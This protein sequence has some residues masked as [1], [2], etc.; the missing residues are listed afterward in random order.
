MNEMGDDL[1]NCILV[2]DVLDKFKEI[3]DSSVDL[4]LTSPPYYGLR[5]YD[6]VKTQ[7]GLEPSLEEYLTRMMQV[8][9]ECKRVL[10]DSGSYW[11][12]IG[13]TYATNGK[14]VKHKDVKYRLDSTA[15]RKSL[16][17]VPER[18]YVRMLDD[19]WLSRNKVLWTKWHAMPASVKDRLTNVHEPLYFFTKGE[20]YY[21]NLELV[22]E[23]TV[24]K[25]KP[26]NVRVRDVKRGLGQARL[27]HATDAEI[28]RYD[29]HGHKIDTKAK[30]PTLDPTGNSARLSV[31]FNNN[32]GYNNYDKKI[33]MNEHLSQAEKESAKRELAKIKGLM[34]EGK[35]TSFRMYLRNE[36]K[37]VHGSNVSIS[38]RAREVRDKGYSFMIIYSTGKNPGDLLVLPFQPLPR[39]YKHHAVFPLRLPEFVL[40]ASAPLF[41]CCKCGKPQMPEALIN[42]EK[43]E[44]PDKD[45]NT[46]LY[47][48]CDCNAEWKA[49]RVLDMFAGAGTTLCVAK[50]FGLR[51][52]GI[53]INANYVELMKER[54]RDTTKPFKSPLKQV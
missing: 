4:I 8:N 15:P 9:K 36:G 45:V 26:Y 33:D 40:G 31:N 20:D 50:A 47:P 42:L 41:V 35:V 54:L 27:T 5:V 25:T 32:R 1:S 23:P 10:K 46:A 21:F 30:F 2:G 34:L 11:L 37:G 53:E 29:K 39:K 49:G 13:D 3:P 17:G 44:G 51:Y 6:D 43:W 19:K 22:K 12:N 28:Q 18:L 14:V 16:M 52:V 7:W 48:Q 24:G 38:G